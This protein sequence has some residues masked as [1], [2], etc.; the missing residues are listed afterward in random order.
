LPTPPLKELQL[1]AIKPEE[2]TLSQHTVCWLHCAAPVSERSGEHVR[3]TGV[4]EFLS[5]SGIKLYTS[6]EKPFDWS[7]ELA[8]WTESQ[9][10]RLPA[11]QTLLPGSGP[12]VDTLEV[13]VEVA[14]EVVVDIAVVI[15]AE[16][17]VV[18]VAEVVTGG[19]G[20]VIEV[21]LKGGGAGVGVVEVVVL[22]GQMVDVKTTAV[23]PLVQSRSS[24]G[25]AP[26]ERTERTKEARTEKSMASECLWKRGTGRID[27][28]RARRGRTDR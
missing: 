4:F 3:P 14:V 15:G 7:T 2:W 28:L 23:H 19:K 27:V 6:S 13:A 10:W 22:E 17:D 5:S 12:R 20:G 1:I 24:S 21:E 26:T 18:V 11:L 8:L 9:H 16:V 25:A